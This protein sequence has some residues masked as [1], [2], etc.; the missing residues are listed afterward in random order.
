M[1]SEIE[2][3]LNF[4]QLNL[5][6]LEDYFDLID[7]QEQLNSI[8]PESKVKH[9]KSL[10]NLISLIFPCKIPQLKS[11]LLLERD[12]IFAIA[13]TEFNENEHMHFRLLIT[14]YE[15][16]LQKKGYFS[17]KINQ[18][19]NSAKIQNYMFTYSSHNLETSRRTSF[20]RFK[21]VGSFISRNS[22]SNQSMKNATSLQ[23]GIQND[24]LK[25]QNG[26][27]KLTNY[28][29]PS[30]RNKSFDLSALNSAKILDQ[31]STSKIHSQYKYRLNDQD[32]SDQQMMLNNNE[33]ECSNQQNTNGN[34][35]SIDSAQ[36]S[37]NSNLEYLSC[38]KFPDM[39][40][41]YLNGSLNQYPSADRLSINH[42]KRNS[43]NKKSNYSSRNSSRSDTYQNSWA[44]SRKSSNASGSRKINSSYSTLYNERV[45]MTI[46]HRSIRYGDHWQE[47][48]K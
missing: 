40:S 31:I 16:L 5:D 7:I 28:E 21:H 35:H 11:S 6:E 37:I 26:N 44:D 42:F 1:I 25:N 2:D 46:F 27:L 14:I 34:D 24:Y 30:K 4:N 13:L 20:R 12:R 32:V 47:I 43:F 33:Q 15:I 9:K 23:I 29:T 19:Q 41:N 18:L 39:N 8:K 48:G 10:Y 3:E 17:A 36:T 38:I 22:F 45:S